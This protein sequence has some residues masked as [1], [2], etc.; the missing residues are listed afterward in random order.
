MGK[1]CSVILDLL[2]YSTDMTQKTICTS[3][4]SAVS[5]FGW[6]EVQQV[7]SFVTDHG[8]FAFG[9]KTV[10]VT[11]Q[12]FRCCWAPLVQFSHSLPLPSQ[13]RRLGLSSRLGGNISRRAA[14]NW[15]KSYS[16][17]HD[18][19]FSI[20]T[21]GKEKEAEI[22]ELWHLSFQ[23]AIMQTEALLPGDSGT[24]GK[25]TFLLCFHTQL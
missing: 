21:P 17:P 15:P 7:N 4:S 23:A 2:Q 10:W 1:N 6:D 14:P 12:C 20:L 5:G 11:Q 25:F 8:G 3:W 16:M 24:N 19:I 18:I 22:S 9:I 13:A